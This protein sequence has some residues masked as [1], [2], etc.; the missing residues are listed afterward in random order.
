MERDPEAREI[1][2]ESDAGTDEDGRG[3]ETRLQA[4]RAAAEAR[5]QGKRRRD[6]NEDDD[7]SDTEPDNVLAQQSS[8]LRMASIIDGTMIT[9][10]YN[11]P[12]EMRKLQGALR[13]EGASER[14][15]A[16]D[17]W[18]QTGL[19]E[20]ELRYNERCAIRRAEARVAYE[21]ADKVMTARAEKRGAESSEGMEHFWWADVSAPMLFGSSDAHRNEME[22]ISLPDLHACC[23]HR[24]SVLSRAR[25]GEGKSYAPLYI[26]ITENQDHVKGF[27]VGLASFSQCRD[28]IAHDEGRM[29]VSSADHADTRSMQVPY[30]V[31]R[32]RGPSPYELYLYNKESNAATVATRKMFFCSGGW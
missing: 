7:E 31:T 30:A 15:S 22:E 23:A 27:K 5:A 28:F 29:Q 16:S 6:P 18:A 12:P 26:A 2:K 8:A 14:A 19:T 4:E 21:A 32:C 3:G 25:G 9:K 10:D 13:V 20:S 1:P 24:L 11:A 17:N